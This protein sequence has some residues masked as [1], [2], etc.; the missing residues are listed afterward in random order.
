M[1]ITMLKHPDL[2]QEQT[3]HFISLCN[4]T[5]RHLCELHRVVVEE[6]ID[7]YKDNI[8]A[9]SQRKLSTLVDELDD[10]I[11]TSVQLRSMLL[12]DLQYH[13]ECKKRGKLDRT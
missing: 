5:V 12:A 6:I 1:D 7:P 10:A 4:S 8:P 11:A 2:N 13:N 9:T 3:R